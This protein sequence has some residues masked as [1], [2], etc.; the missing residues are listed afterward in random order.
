MNVTRLNS[1]VRLNG[2][3]PVFPL[4]SSSTGGAGSGALVVALVADAGATGRLGAV[5]P[6]S[7][8]APIIGAAVVAMPTSAVA[9]ADTASPIKVYGAGSTGSVGALLCRSD[10]AKVRM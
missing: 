10:A 1:V 4:P 9:G 8:A 3:V 2:S 5:V 7:G 6:C